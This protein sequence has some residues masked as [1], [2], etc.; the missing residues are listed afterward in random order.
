MQSY[1][2]HRVYANVLG[3]EGE[4]RVREA[5]GQNYDRLLQLKK[6]YDPQNLF[7]LNQNINPAE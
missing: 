7:R 6:K 3:M 1:S 4:Q 2:S 5:Y